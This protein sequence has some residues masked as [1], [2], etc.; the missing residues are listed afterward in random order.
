MKT[1]HDAEE[2]FLRRLCRRRQTAY[3]TTPRLGDNVAT[4]MKARRGELETNASVIDVWRRLLPAGLYEHTRIAG[5]GA[6]AVYVEVEPGPYMHELQLLR[7]ELC[8]QLQ[9]LCRSAGVRR[10]VLRPR[11]ATGTME[12]L[13]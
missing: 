12:E 3:Y 8:G 13:I 1:D 7:A 11:R 10:I 9:R 6:G 2:M 5:I 4:Y